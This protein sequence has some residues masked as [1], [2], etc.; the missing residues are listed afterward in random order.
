LERIPWNGLIGALGIPLFA[1]IVLDHSVTIANYNVAQADMVFRFLRMGNCSCNSAENDVLH[2]WAALKKKARC[3][4][5]R[6]VSCV[7]GA[8]DGNHVL[9]AKARFDSAD[10]AGEPPVIGL[11]ISLGSG[12]ARI[13]DSFASRVLL[14]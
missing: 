12:T 6:I 14:G 1:E 5:S 11:K 2:P 10:P 13:K 4:C 7:W 3:Y 8:C 9:T